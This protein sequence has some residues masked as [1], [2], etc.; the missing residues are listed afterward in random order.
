[1]EILNDHVVVE[2]VKCT[3]NEIN[4]DENIK[5]NTTLTMD[6]FQEAY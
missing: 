1:M 6:E 3:A 4:K 5:V 2:Y